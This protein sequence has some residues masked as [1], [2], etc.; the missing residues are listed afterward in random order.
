MAHDAWDNMTP[1]TI[2]N[3][4]NHADIQ[5][6]PIILCIPST[7]TQR[8]WNVIHTFVDFSSGMTLPQAEDS[9]EEIFDD[10]YNGNDW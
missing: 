10:Q 3:C 6:D 7:L 5:R 9:L 1:E 2:K 8:G 4:W